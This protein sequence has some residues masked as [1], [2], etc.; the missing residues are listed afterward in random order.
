MEIINKTVYQDLQKVG[1]PDE[2]APVIASH[3]PD[4]S[5]FATKQDLSRLESQMDRRM[6][7]M[8]QK[9]DRLESRMDQKMETLR[10]EIMWP[11]TWRMILVVGIPFVLLALERYLP[12]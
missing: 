2:Q 6:D 1:M 7:Q 3:L 5:Q 11:M 4:W 12:A 10:H 9:I 8:N